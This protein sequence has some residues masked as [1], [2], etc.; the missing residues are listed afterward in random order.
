LKGDKEIE[1]PKILEIETI[2]EDKTIHLKFF[3]EIREIESVD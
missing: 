2:S 1:T 3:R